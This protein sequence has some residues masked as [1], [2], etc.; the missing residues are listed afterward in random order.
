M[1][2]TTKQCCKFHKLGGPRGMKC[3]NYGSV[4]DEEEITIDS[5]LP[6][7]ASVEDWDAYRNAAAEAA[8]AG[9]DIV[10]TAIAEELMGQWE[11]A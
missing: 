1:K 3:D 5:Q 6:P 10:E 8:S 9:V 2:T 4:V 7:L 11:F